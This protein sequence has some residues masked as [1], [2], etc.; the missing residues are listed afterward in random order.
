MVATFGVMMLG[1]L[2]FQRSAALAEEKAGVV[3]KSCAGLERRHDQPCGNKAGLRDDLCN[4]A[5]SLTRTLM[6]LNTAGSASRT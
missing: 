3:R 4:A 2:E 5:Y 1:Q 6:P